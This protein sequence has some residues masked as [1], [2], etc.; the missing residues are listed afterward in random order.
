M[1]H[2]MFDVDG[3]LVE[4]A[5]FD[6]SCFTAAVETVLGIDIDHDLSKYAHVTHAGIV[7][8]I[9]APE[10]PSPERLRL[11]AAVKKQYVGNIE[12]YILQHHIK[13]ISGAAEFLQKLRSEQDVSI[14][15]ATG[16]WYETAI[17]KLEAA[18][19]DASNLPI[20]TSND[21]YDRSTIMQI[22]RQ[23]SGCNETTPCTYFGDG[24][25]DKAA[26]QKLGYNFVLVGHRAEH[27]QRIDNFMQVKT[28]LDY[29]GL[30]KHPLAQSL[31]GGLAHSPEH[32]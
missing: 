21:H 10:I 28:A 27:E 29:I 7:R 26:C 30:Q 11:T 18:G 8:Q 13:P 9:I 16:G 2:V 17:K 12:Q 1:H 15:I 5:D 4:S 24:A 20:A 22:A 6:F 23:K 31:P 3:T 14:S 32:S 19:I 25:W